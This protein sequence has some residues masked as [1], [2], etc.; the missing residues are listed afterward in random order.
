MIASFTPFGPDFQLKTNQRKLIVGCLLLLSCLQLLG[1]PD[2]GPSET[3]HL[4][5]AKVFPISCFACLRVS[6]G[7]KGSGLSCVPGNS[8]VAALILSSA[9][10]DLRGTRTIAL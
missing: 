6:A 3:V 2:Q 7:G 9:D 10:C 5:H 4:V 1:P 8:D